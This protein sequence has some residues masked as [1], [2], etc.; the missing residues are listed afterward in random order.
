M[1]VEEW[2]DESNAIS[3]GEITI[4]SK[5]EIEKRNE[6]MTEGQAAAIAIM[7]DLTEKRKAFK[8]CLT[9]GPDVEELK[10]GEFKPFYFI[11]S[12]ET[13]IRV[14]PIKRKLNRYSKHYIAKL[15]IKTG[16]L[17]EPVDTNNHK[18]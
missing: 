5:E 1:S 9:V 3:P 14:I 8:E 17:S 7:Q 12:L 10:P 4:P 2:K 15:C 13:Y 16:K 6:A 18:K 11:Q